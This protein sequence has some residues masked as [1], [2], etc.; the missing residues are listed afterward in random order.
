MKRR[1]SAVLLALASCQVL[2]QTPAA[3]AAAEAA[4][5]TASQAAAASAVP[6]SAA[7][8]EAVQPRRMV[9]SPH[10]EGLD[11]CDVAQADTQLNTMAK[12]R[13]VCQGLG[14]TSAQTL[15]KALDAL[16]PGG[17][18]GQVQVG[19]TLTVPLL[20]MFRAEGDDWV[21]D[22]AKLQPMLDLIEE[23]DRPVVIYLSSSH[24]DTIGPL[25]EALRQDPRNFMQYADGSVPQ[26]GYFGFPISAYTLLTDPD[27]PVNRYRFKALHELAARFKGMSEAARSRIV[28]YSLGGELHQM[29]PDFENGAGQFQQVRVTDYSPASVAAFREWLADKWG[30]VR[31][32]SA[33]TGIAFDSFDTI[34]APRGNLKD[35]STK[36]WREHYDAYASGYLPIAGWLHDPKGRVESLTLYLNGKPQGEVQRGY[37]RLDVYRAKDEVLTPNVGYRHDLDV[38][39]LAPG[40]YLVQVV[41]TVDGLNYELAHTRFA[42]AARKPGVLREREPTGAR[43]LQVV[44]QPG[45]WLVRWWRNFLRTIGME[46]GAP[47]YLPVPDVESYLDLPG[48]DASGKDLV[49]HYNPL[50]REW[51]EF[52]N[53]QVL[54]YMQA[55]YDQAID[56]GLAQGEV[57]SHQLNDRVNSA[58]NAQLFAVDDVWAERQDWGAGMNLYGGGTNNEAVLRFIQRG[59]LN[60]ASPEF[61]TQQWKV[62]GVPLQALQGLRDVGARFVSPYYLGLMPQHLRGGQV[63]HGV[64]RMELTPSNPKD[65]SDQL[66]GAIQELARQ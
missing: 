63:E 35:G 21:I 32:L 56:A 59:K 10:V 34:D 20:G 25:P 53:H 46:R 31:K 47:A 8:S 19:Y 7:S 66:Y 37:N 22:E 57:Y 9:L 65:G 28:G 23:V 52:R 48:K 1:T 43:K 39:D 50:A 54:N 38:S 16:E 6:A 14:A 61:H 13:R 55:L 26:L 36:R 42:M 3:S 44:Q 12:V 5:H 60:F 24:F 40:K 11:V 45:S 49:V 17:A 30:S 64:N 4:S 27:I 18:Q 41:A 29:Y 33:A 58:W 62:P 15:M 51:D 2:A